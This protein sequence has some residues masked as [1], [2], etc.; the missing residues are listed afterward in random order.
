MGQEP[1]GDRSGRGQAFGDHRQRHPAAQRDG[2]RGQRVA[3]VVAARQGQRDLGFT[4]RA[5]QGEARA[6]S[7]GHDRAGAD[8][9]TGFQ[10]EAQHPPARHQGGEVFAEG[11]V[12]VDHRHSI[13]RQ[14]AVDRALGLG[15]AQQA[16]QAFQVRG[17]DVVDQ[18][19]VRA[20]DPGQ[21][22]D[23]ARLA[24]AHFVDGEL[25]LVRRLDH[26]QRQ[27][28]LV[29]A[30]AGAGIGLAGALQDGAH[31]HLD[32]GLAVA[33]GDRHDLAAA[34]ALQAGGK[35]GQGQLGVGHDHLRQLGLDRVLDQ[36]RRRASLCGRGDKVVPIKAL[37]T[38]GHV[39]AAA[40]QRAGVVGHCVH[41]GVLAV[42]V[43]AGQ[44]GDERERKPVHRRTCAGSGARACRAMRACTVSSKA[45][46]TPP[47]S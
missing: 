9:G 7:L 27:A 43:A 37:A 29:V 40:A 23:V 28:D 17:G 46:L 34:V 47:M 11:I 5:D 1:A 3:H 31:Q 15:H 14:R 12:G 6:L 41:R 26:R 18:G 42:Q 13:G 10:A 16:A 36:Q 38:Q 21:V 32:A 20:R 30:I 19:H 22:G 39:Q 4:V 25:G 35:P 45:C 8:L 2:R 24:G 33:A 44:V